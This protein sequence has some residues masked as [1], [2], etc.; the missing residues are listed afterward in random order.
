M[1]RALENSTLPAWAQAWGPQLV[2]CEEGA[3]GDDFCAAGMPVGAAERAGLCVH[4]FGIASTKDVPDGWWCA[5]SLFHS[6]PHCS[7][8]SP[9]AYMI[10]AGNCLLALY[11]CKVAA[12]LWRALTVMQRSSYRSTIGAGLL[13]VRLL[14]LACVVTWGMLYMQASQALPSG[15]SLNLG[16]ATRFAPILGGTLLVITISAFV[17]VAAT[18]Y[19]S[20][21]G[22][23]RSG[24]VS[25]RRL[26]LGLGTVVVFWMLVILIWLVGGLRE[27]L[28]CAYLLGALA[29]CFFAHAERLLSSTLAACDAVVNGQLHFRLLAASRRVRDVRRHGHILFPLVM[30]VGVMD[31]AGLGQFSAPI[32]QLPSYAFRS[33]AVWLRWCVI[34]RTF[35]SLTNFLE[36]PF[37]D[38]PP[39]PTVIGQKSGELPSTSGEHKVAPI[40]N[41]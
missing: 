5:C 37:T 25:G 41:K 22:S 26:Y 6:G 10:V 28:L 35:I 24:L 33:V 38:S 21:S 15:V 27:A 30:I 20:A 8:V 13:S 7:D 29:F 23:P 31:Y 39:T 40:S 12:R 4:L 9:G 14:L 34:G 3:R 2:A 36:G 19:E 17:C 1:R 16:A 11:F 32:S 18:V